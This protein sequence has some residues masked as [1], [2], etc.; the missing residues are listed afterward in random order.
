MTPLSENFRWRAH[1]KRKCTIA[2]RRVGCFFGSRHFSY[3]QKKKNKNK[4][5]KAS[6]SRSFQENKQTPPPPPPTPP[7]V[8]GTTAI[9]LPLPLPPSL[10]A[11]FLNSPLYYRQDVDG[12]VGRRRPG[13][14]LFGCWK[15]KNFL[16]SRCRPTGRKIHLWTARVKMGNYLCKLL[17]RILCMVLV[18]RDVLGQK[19]GR[20]ERIVWAMMGAAV[21]VINAWERMEG[22]I[23]WK[24]FQCTTA[25]SNRGVP[26]R[27]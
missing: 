26:D 1:R 19:F 21:V 15:R 16:I 9:P 17:C 20:S 24:L 7:K 6:S 25:T 13:R 2:G 14:S 5:M 27:K 8:F 12:D 18:F 11:H 23:V 4:L 3:T 22:V 10:Q